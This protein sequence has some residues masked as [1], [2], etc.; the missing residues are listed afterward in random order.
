METDLSYLWC[1]DR[2]VLKI[3][4]KSHH[5]LRIIKDEN[6]D[7]FPP[8]QLTDFSTNWAYLVKPNDLLVIK[9]KLGN[10]VLCNTVEN[11]LSISV[12]FEKEQN[13]LLGIHTLKTKVLHDPMPDDYSHSLI[14]VIHEFSPSSNSEEIGFKVE[15]TRENYKTNKISRKSFKDFR[16]LYR[17]EIQNKVFH[18]K[19]NLV[20][21]ENMNGFN[22]FFKNE[23]NDCSNKHGSIFLF[24]ILIIL[25]ILLV[26]QIV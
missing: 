10:K 24:V 8:G 17:F 23:T 20:P 6:P 9:P 19:N 15:V 7:L 26:S 21:K 5:L 25:F 22:E 2:P 13:E 11:I 1:D 14:D 3:D 12:S 4:N 16:N 18:F